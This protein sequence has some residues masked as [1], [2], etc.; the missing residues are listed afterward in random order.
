MKSSAFALLATV[1]FLFSCAVSAQNNKNPADTGASALRQTVDTAHAAWK[2]AGGAEFKSGVTYVQGETTFMVITTPGEAA[3]KKVRRK[4][5]IVAA[6]EFLLDDGTFSKVAICVVE[7]DAR[8]PE[9]QKVTNFEVRR[10]NYQEAIKKAARVED[11]K[12]AGRKA[13]ETDS[14][15]ESV[16]TDLGI[17]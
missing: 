1:S 8:N 3:D 5:A 2:K 12:E 15:M 4:R 17:K 16:C 10:G 14:I 13:K 6:C 9:N 7:V 11:I